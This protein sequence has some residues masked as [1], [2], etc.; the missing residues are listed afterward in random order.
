MAAPADLARRPVGQ[1]DGGS[2][3]RRQVEVEVEAAGVV[4]PPADVDRALTVS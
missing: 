4:Q 2:R 3:R 1:D